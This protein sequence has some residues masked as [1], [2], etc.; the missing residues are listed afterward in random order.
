MLVF[1]IHS[2]FSS[3]SSSFFLPTTLQS[4]NGCDLVRKSELADG[5]ISDRSAAAGELTRE[6]KKKKK[7]KRKRKKKRIESRGPFFSFRN[8]RIIFHPRSVQAASHGSIKDRGYCSRTKK[9]NTHTHTRKIHQPI[10]EERER[11][12][13]TGRR[14][15]RNRKCRPRTTNRGGNPSTPS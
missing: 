10:E 4:P 5:S 13:P 11:K 6:A 14:T 1:T 15:G 9:R 8:G 2:T 12:E 7:E 3:S